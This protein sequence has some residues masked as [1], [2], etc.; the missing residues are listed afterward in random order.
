MK[1]FVADLANFL[2]ELQSADVKNAPAAGRHNFYRGGSLMAY[3]TETRQAI[4]R[5]KNVLNADILL[6]IWNAATKPRQG[7]NDVW[8]HG[9]VA[10]GN[11]LESNGV[12]CAVIDFG[13]CA[14]GDPACDYVMAW[15]FFDKECRELFFEALGCDRDTIARAK[16][17]ALWKALITYGDDL[18]IR[19]MA[20][21]L[22]D[23]PNITDQTSHRG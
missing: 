6:G 9:D 15:T 16:G 12:L 20:A 3:D 17:W 8:V 14:V 13:C 23:K 22:N 5:L 19:T 11:L 2:K 7:R 10:V 1:K 21:I 18:S 4:D